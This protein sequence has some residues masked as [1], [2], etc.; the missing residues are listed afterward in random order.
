MDDTI[1]G[2]MLGLS[3]LLVTTTAVGLWIR[4]IT[5]VAIGSSRIWYIAAFVLATG[6]SVTALIL[7]THWVGNVAGGLSIFV[8]LFF[9]LTAAIG[10]QKVGTSA[11]QIGS[12]LPA[13]SGND[14]HGK[15]F[16]SSELLGKPALIK[17]FRGHW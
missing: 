14:E 13:F 15:C 3:A 2:T 8:A 17:F 7:N 1:V 12:T 16:D 10:P 6:M 11:I 9:F 4:A 5:T